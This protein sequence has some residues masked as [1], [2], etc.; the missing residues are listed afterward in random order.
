MY[1]VRK[2]N[3]MTDRDDIEEKRVRQKTS[4]KHVFAIDR[5]VWHAACALGLNEAV[6]YLVIASGTGGDNR[7]SFWSSTAIETYTALNHSRSAK[8]AVLRL[9]NEGLLSVQKISERRPRYTLHPPAL[10]P[11]VHAAA[12]ELGTVSAL[13]EPDLI[14]LPNSIVHGV[15]QESSPV[16]ILRQAQSVGALKT[17]V[18]LYYFHDL[19]AFGGLE[20]QPPRGILCKFN[21]TFIGERGAFNI[22]KF[23]TPA[24]MITSASPL[25]VD[26]FD[27]HWR[28]IK[29]LGLIEFVT[30]LVE[31]CAGEIIHPLPIGATGEP[32]ERAITAAA[33]RA[34]RLMVAPLSRDLKNGDAVIVPVSASYPQVELVGIGRLRYRPQTSR[35]AQWL[36]GS[37]Q[38]EKT[39]LAF[40]ELADSIA[41]SGIK[42][43]S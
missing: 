34:G 23:D 2:E 43:A 15:G 20:W 10:V 42:V 31:S 25:H 33:L 38:W 22:W 17:F 12:A 13:E 40:E 7:T 41:V 29:R 16:K 1:P 27:Q 4:A 32:E 11:I 18:D 39:A 36:A 14:W 28:I 8:P 6:C 19:P 26:G 24:A 30:H 21:R 3:A 5:R 9:V 37:S 35:T